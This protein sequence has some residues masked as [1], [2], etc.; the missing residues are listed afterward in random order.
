[1]R[2][3]KKEMIREWEVDG[4]SLQSLPGQ[5]HLLGWQL[6]AQVLAFLVAVGAELDVD[7]YR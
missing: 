7:E 2:R 3:A 4:L 1:M 6:D 5:H